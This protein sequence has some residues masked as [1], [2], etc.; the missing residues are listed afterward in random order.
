M[1]PAP[2]RAVLLANGIPRDHAELAVRVGELRVAKGWNWGTLAK[3][4]GPGMRNT[5]IRAIERGTHNPT[6]STL[7]KLARALD[8]R[9]LDELLGELPFSALR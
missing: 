9:S 6:F 8:L 3:E 1:Q 2:N 7:M 5:Q 4:A